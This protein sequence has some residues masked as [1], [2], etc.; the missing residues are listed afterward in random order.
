M[1]NVLSGPGHEIVQAN[2]IN[3]TREQ[4][5][6]KVRADESS[7]ARQDRSLPHDPPVPHLSSSPRDSGVDPPGTYRSGA[8]QRANVISVRGDL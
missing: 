6:R 5:F 4:A 1:S 7:A 2:Y 3:A 8:A